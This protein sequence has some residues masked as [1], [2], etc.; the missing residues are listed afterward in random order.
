MQL[1]RRALLG[2]IGV[3]AGCTSSTVRA[4][5]TVPLD[6][7]AWVNSTLA[8]LS[9]EQKVGQLIMG[10]LEGD[11]ENVRGAELQ[12]IIHLIRAYHVGGFAVGIGSPAEVA[13]KLNT[14]QSAAQV[15]LLIAADLEWGA[16]MRLW[17]PTYLPYG[18]E[19]GGGTA[20]PFNMGV[21]ATRDPALADT[22]GRITG[23][24]A[25]AVGIHWVFAPVL[26]VNTDA[27]NPVINVRSYGSDPHEVARFGAAFVRGAN[28]ARVL[29]AAKHFPGHG[30]TH[31]DS[32]V[33][34]PVLD[35]A[36]A[37]LDSVEL[38][39]FRA[40]VRSGVTGVMLGHLAIPNLIGDRATP[41]SISAAIGQEL[42]RKQL[43]FN[44]LIVTDALTMG[45]LRNVPGY[46]AGEIAVRA[47][48][49]GSDVILSPPDV[50][51]AHSAL[52]AAVRS[53]RI[54]PARLDSSVQ[55]ILG[56]KAWLGLQRQRQVDVAQ[57]ND[58]VASP[59][60]E[61]AAAML[62]AR[63]LTLV[64]DSANVLPLDPRKYR[65]VAVIAF[66]AANDIGAGRALNSEMRAIYGRGLTFLR[67]DENMGAA[68]FDQAVQQ[69]GSADAIVLATFLMPISGQGHIQVP[70]RT[71]EIAGRLAALNKPMVVVSFG[72]PYG[73]ALLPGSG[74]YLLAWQPRGEHAQRA[75]ARA[76][77]GNAAITG[78]L[79]VDVAG[80]R[81]NTGLRRAVMTGDLTPARPSQVGMNDSILAR[82][83]SIISAAL[84]SGAS[85]G[86]AVA[87]GRYGRLIKL[88]GYGNLDY[89][90][91]FAPVT[92]SSIYDVASLT[93]VVATTTAAMMLIEDGKLQL[94]APLSRYL[95]ELLATPDKQNITVRNVLLH[96]AGFRAFAPLW[97]NARGPAEF[98][99]EIAALP[100]EYPTG[101]RTIY[102]DFGP[103]LLGI[104]ME[105]I[106]GQPLDEF[107][108]T[109][110]FDPLGMRETLYN[111]LAQTLARAG[112][113]NAPDDARS[114]FFAR[115]APT[116][117]DTLFRRQHMHGRVHDENAFAFGGVAGHAGLFSSAR[118]LARFAQMLLNGGYFNGRRFLSPETISLFTRRQSDASSRALGWD[119]P[120]QNSSAGDYFTASAWGHTGFTGTSMWM[121]PERQLFIVLL[122]NR[123]NPTR[124]NQKHIPLRRALADAVN[125]AITDMAVPKRT[126]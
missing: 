87:I 18:I 96:N 120:A 4:P 93:K 60:H 36:R 126:W 101:A 57:I 102:S 39:P 38:V 122:T 84:A 47:F 45:A 15:P 91:G 27:G 2:L 74:T 63:S 94:D 29:T 49:A 43:A 64:R 9:V 51:Q 52:V 31:I 112:N 32:H 35:V 25:R 123:V 40:A 105:R 11:F 44:G 117:I 28:S 106:S 19:G 16:G 72:D 7:A 61:H 85:P 115:I 46:T 118:D 48:E 81:R 23:R 78:L 6:S 67:L 1:T 86:A 109:R 41:S 111:P 5:A 65:R 79:P 73:P 125:Q 92:D 124:D 90:P 30:D 95:P 83:D 42:L 97:R 58:V 114:P 121:D 54:T 71:T 77:A 89:R 116:E 13:L 22:A 3:L 82:V 20:F 10:R 66:G 107:V 56:A 119:T 88:R 12:R 33:E 68:A 98:L 104:A 24:E 76:L 8:A 34:L 50:A 108:K 59:D 17:R 21:G 99:K 75:A 26:D 113:T 80:A 55:R 14:L 69:A 100:L 53:G 110:L 70:A 37:R 62:A 103:I